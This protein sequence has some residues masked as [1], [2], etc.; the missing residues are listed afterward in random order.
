MA[1]VKHEHYVNN[2]EFTALVTEWV[3]KY[4]I[5]K[6]AEERLPP[7][8]I[9]IADSFYKIAKRYSSKPNFSGYTYKDDMIGEAIYI[10]IRYAHNFNPEKSNN[11]FAY[12]TQ[13][14]HNA[15]IQYI[16]KEKKYTKFKFD[17]LKDADEKIGKNDF[18]DIDLYYEDEDNTGISDLE[19]VEKKILKTQFTPIEQL[20][21]DE[22]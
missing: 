20:L 16:N 7:I 3:K 12:F 4:K 9:E 11:A 19:K 10:C 21:K 8:P 6:A 13:Y 5:A 15:F 14:C 17:L 2:K 18:N 1:K 22:L